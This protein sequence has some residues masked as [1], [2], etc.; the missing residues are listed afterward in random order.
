M[1][2]NENLNYEKKMSAD[3]IS[4]AIRKCLISAFPLNVAKA[5]EQ[6]ACYTKLQSPNC[7]LH[8]HPNSVLFK[9]LAPLVVYGQC[10][11]TTKSFMKFVTFVEADWLEEVHPQLYKQIKK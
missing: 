9:R 1:Y 7:T 8:V 3:E 10:V 11:E 5:D 6:R 4:I 2:S